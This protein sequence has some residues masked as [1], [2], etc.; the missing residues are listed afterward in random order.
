LRP[1]PTKGW[2][3]CPGRVR[4]SSPNEKRSHRR[5][6][7]GRDRP[8][9]SP[10]A[11]PGPGPGDHHQ[12]AAYGKPETSASP[13]AARRTL[14]VIHGPA[15][16]IASCPT[17]ASRGNSPRAS[18]AN[19]DTI[20]GVDV[21]TKLAARGGRLRRGLSCRSCR[22]PDILARVGYGTTRLKGPRGTGV[23]VSDFRGGPGTSA[24]APSTCVRRRSMA[25]RVDYNRQEVQPRRRP[26][27]RL[28]PR[29]TSGKFLVRAGFRRRR[30]FVPFRTPALEGGPTPFAGE[31]FSLTGWSVFRDHG[32]G[33]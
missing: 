23:S 10:A 15:G 17:L 4:S 18:R 22:T 7:A 11:R 16:A 31:A 6:L 21:N 9:S 26:R 32:F 13:M 14:G 20:A 3:G 8:P 24:S 5:G 30:A 19:S 29:A 12:P 25:L 28:G 2:A 1:I 27:Q 33:F